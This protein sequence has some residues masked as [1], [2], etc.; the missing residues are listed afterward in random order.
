M[1]TEMPN[2]RK[3][4]L[5]LSLT[6]GGDA[7]AHKVMTLCP[8]EWQ[9]FQSQQ[10]KAAGGIFAVTAEWF[11]AVEAIVFIG[12][13]GIAVRAV[14]P[15]LQDKFTDPAVLV[16]DENGRHVISLLSGHLG[17]ANQ[18]ARDIAALI[19]AEPVITTAT[20]TNEKAS[21]D[22]ILQALNCPV[23]HYRDL[24]LEANKKLISGE[25]IHLSV[26]EAF[27]SRQQVADRLKRRKLCLNGIDFENKGRAF[28]NN[29]SIFFENNNGISLDDHAA[30]ALTI[31]I[32]FAA[33]RTIK[34][35]VK[36]I[37]K[38]FALGSGSKKNVSTDNYQQQLDLFLKQQD[39]LPEAIACLASVALKSEEVCMLET[40]EK[41]GW[42]TC[43]YSV[44][45]LK[46]FD[47]QFPAS[48]TVLKA[49]DLRA[50][51]GPA[52]MKAAGIQIKDHRL[53]ETYKS[54]GCTFT[55][56]RIQND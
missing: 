28:E 51:S 40:A 41:Y 48:D 14:A 11:H 45:T 47:E 54:G 16:L 15:H 33:S 3:P 31:D 2:K 50:V 35:A 7:L 49:L 9:G 43:F 29:N 1:N 22:L 42:A 55:L 12:A 23:A 5:M 53:T 20:D 56:G 6:P 27:L 46:D 39:V 26:D 34:T 37:P 36:V 44:E 24:C 30:A 25:T 19:G 38:A 17:G 13:A 10:I 52:A 4:M 8:G 18:L 32:S 21:L